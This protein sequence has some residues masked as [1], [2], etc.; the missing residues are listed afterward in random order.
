M[1]PSRIEAN[2]IKSE[3]NVVRRWTIATPQS[4][5]TQFEKALA[6]LSYNG[7]CNLVCK[8]AANGTV[9]IFEINP[10]LGG[11]LMLPQYKDQLQ[12]ALTCIVA[13]AT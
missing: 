8:F 10:R 12:Q 5:V 1:L 9:R 4:V 11:S 6:P 7:P 2:I 3:D 13:N